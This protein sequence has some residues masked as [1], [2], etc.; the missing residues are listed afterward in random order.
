M[1]SMD[2]H[3][4]LA[5]TDLTEGSDEVLRAAAALADAAGASLHVVHAFDLDLTAYPELD[6]TPTFQGRIA[7]AEEALAA[8]L[9]RTVPDGAGAA[10]RQVV[11]YVAHRAILD[12]AAEVRADV[13]V[14]GPHR[15]RAHADRLLG[16]TADRVIRSAACPCLVVRGPLAL[17]L[18]RVVVPLDLSDP[19]RGALATAAGWVEAFGAGDPD[20]ALPDVELDVVHV[21]PRLFAAGGLP[22]NRAT[23][24][25]RLHRDVE[26]VLAEHAFGVTVREE[27]VWG[28]GPADEIARYARERQAQLVVLATHG[29]GALKRALIGSAASAVARSA[30]CPVLLVP[31]SR[32]SGEEEEAGETEERVAAGAVA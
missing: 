22:V 13:I 28:D 21:V 29:H 17:P 1:P 16:T 18:R 9:A 11:V 20:L 3:A 5:A 2:I 7:R 15:G 32:W 30:P 6:G 24:G 4:V 27:L 26:E 19:A 31:P 23:I 25:P 10:S 14:L 12:R 8:Q